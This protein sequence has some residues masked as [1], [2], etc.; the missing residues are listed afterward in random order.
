MKSSY[1]AASITNA[2]RMALDSFYDLHK[3]DSELTQK[4]KTEVE[5]VSHREYDTG[6]FYGHPETE[7]KIVANPEYIREKSYL[8]ICVHYD[9]KNSTAV[10]EQKNKVILYQKAQILSPSCF[11]EDIFIGNLSD[12]ND[13]PVESAP[14]PFMLFKIKI[15]DNIKNPN[16]VWHKKEIKPGDIIRSV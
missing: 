13:N 12:E 15:D 10:F 8:G 4:L 9:R 3:I 11:G 16:P 1:Y 14:H 5:S 2:Y 6:Y 7:A